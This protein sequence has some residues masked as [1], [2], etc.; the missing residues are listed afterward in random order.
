MDNIEYYNKIE[1][2]KLQ[3]EKNTNLILNKIE[4]L[5]VEEILNNK[6]EIEILNNINTLF[7]LDYVY[8]RFAQQ[9]MLSSMKNIPVSINKY[10]RFNEILLNTTGKHLESKIIDLSKYLNKYTSYEFSFND[11]FYLLDNKYD[12]QNKL[13]LEFIYLYNIIRNDIYDILYT[14]IQNEWP[15]L[16]DYI[17][18]YFSFN[19][20]LYSPIIQDYI[21]NNFDMSYGT[22]LLI[23]LLNSIFINTDK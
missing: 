17:F 21:H 10:N 7:K 4:E 19:E 5:Q 14:N 1:S 8:A 3:Y 23:N 16:S 22:D 12:D 2:Y 20:K 13:Y 9:V 15:A 11:T 18:V 6:S